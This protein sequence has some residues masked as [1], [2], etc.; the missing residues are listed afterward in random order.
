MI[1][2][3]NVHWLNAVDHV[4]GGRM[5]IPGISH[6]P[7]LRHRIVDPAG[8]PVPNSIALTSA[9]RFSVDYVRIGELAQRSGTSTRSLRYYE[10]HGLLSAGRSANGYREYS[11]DDLRLVREI[12][13]LLDIGFGLEETRPFVECLRAGNSAG[14]ACPAS[15]EVY[16][17]KI[18]ELD[19]CIS[20][21]QRIRAHLQTQ[22]DHPVPYCD[23]AGEH[24]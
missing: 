22:L 18:A 21:L 24:S 6:T 5:S 11:E 10:S 13:S 2:G 23:S 17:H 1:A 16:R 19:A 3:E 20:R 12:R 7:V 14:D 9:S 4:S 15:I 8:G